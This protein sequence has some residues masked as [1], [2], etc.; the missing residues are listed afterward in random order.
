MAILNVKAIGPNKVYPPKREA[1]R[2]AL[3][4]RWDRYYNRRYA[5]LFGTSEPP[6]STILEQG[7]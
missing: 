6:F 1:S 3:M 5:G 4:N 7:R 2:V